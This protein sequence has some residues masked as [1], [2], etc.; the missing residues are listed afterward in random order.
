MPDTGLADQPD[1]FWMRQ[2][3][4]HAARGRGRVE[5]N[6]MV[7][8][9][10]VANGRMVACGHHDRFGGPHA[11]V[12]ALTAA[13]PEARGATLYV[14]LEPCCH[15][16]KTPPCTDA[17]I[18]SGI[19]RVVTAMRDPFPKV[20]GGGVDRLQ[21]AGL[22]VVVGVE[23][24]AARRLN[25]PYLIRLTENRPYVI[26]KWA[27]TLDGKTACSTG[28]SRWIS[29]ERSRALVH[30]LRGRMDGI[31]AGI[32]TVLTDD[33]MLTARPP[34]PRT[35]A[36]V[37]LDRSARLPL[38][39]RLVRTAREIPVLVAASRADAPADRVSALERAGCE[40]VLFDT[41]GPVPVA[42]L[43][44]HLGDRD[45]TNLLIEGGGRVLGSFLD[46]DRV[47]EV[48]VDVAPILEG[49]THHFSPIRGLGRQLMS[50]AARLVDREVT[51]IDG[52]VRIRGR[53]DRS[54]PSLHPS[55]NPLRHEVVRDS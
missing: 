33:P 43:L 1:A 30:D 13:G 17:V 25:A 28:D 27:M 34:G 29:S 55:P 37:V 21:S 4:A 14:T 3:L 5:P 10:V 6:P 19:R 52:D 38:E 51:L 7:G 41:P 40:V 31:V 22:D 44:N 54:A 24:T 42:E 16:G 45:W 50:H 32:G 23:E 11:E 20:Q 8:A 12:V 48:H 2:A 47:D 35:P 39:S 36:R 18:A 53:I 46:A 15:F 26:A 49:G 9:I